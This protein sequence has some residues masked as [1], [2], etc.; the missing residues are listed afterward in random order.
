MTTCLLGTLV[1][2][3]VFRFF[4]PGVPENRADFET[5][6]AYVGE[7][8]PL[9]AFKGINWDSVVSVHRTIADVEGST[10]GRERLLRLLA[11]LRDVHVFLY[12]PDGSQYRAW[13]SPRMARDRV[14]W[15]VDLL[16]N[17]AVRPFG[18][19][20][21]GQMR[22]TMLRDGVGYVWV[23]DFKTKGNGTWAEHLDGIIASMNGARGL[24]I[25]VRG[26]PGGHGMMVYRLAG[27]FLKASMPMPAA[28]FRRQP[29]VRDPL[30]PRGQHYAGPVVV[31]TNGTSNSGAE[32]FAEVMK[33]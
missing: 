17:Y 15:N 16:G 3:S 29:N 9:F 24:V 14:V 6:V 33:Q 12:D 22:F 8:Y 20:A 11:E 2:C 27:R 30:V 1:G 23:K 4:D 32:H 26:N 18:K 19:V 25:D 5:T 7:H 21:D 28:T 13:E 31:L 10:R